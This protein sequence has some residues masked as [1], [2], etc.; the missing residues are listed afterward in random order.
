MDSIS[1]RITDHKTGSDRTITISEPGSIVELASTETA[2]VVSTPNPAA[3]LEWSGTLCDGKEAKYVA[4]EKAC[5]ALGEGWRLPTRFE[6]ESILDLTRSDPAIDTAK[7]PDTKSGY[8]WTSTPYAAHPAYAW[9]VGF[10]GG[11]VYLSRRDD[12]LA[13]VRAVRSVPAS[14]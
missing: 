6:L 2:R 7:F 3:S 12:D 1:V 8:Y 9:V 14:Q 13:F 4:A 10:G 11:G 5:A